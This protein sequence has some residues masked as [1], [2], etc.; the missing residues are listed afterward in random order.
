MAERMIRELAEHEF[1]GSS[2]VVVVSGGSAMNATVR[3]RLK[4]YCESAG[5][6]V[7]LFIDDL[8]Q[9]GYR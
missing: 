8:E 1:S 9:R 7:P 6:D 5:I 2:K 3:K 4:S